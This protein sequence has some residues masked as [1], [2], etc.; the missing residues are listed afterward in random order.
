[1]NRRP[2][3]RR[4]LEQ[5]LVINPVNMKVIYKLKKM[6]SEDF[7]EKE[8]DRILRKVYNVTKDPGVTKRLAII[9]M[10]RR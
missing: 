2:Q 8:A 3:A 1:M 6:L 4:E 10:K 5:A 7:G 9:E